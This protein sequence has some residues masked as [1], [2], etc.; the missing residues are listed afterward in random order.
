MPAVAFKRYQAVLDG[1][2]M[3]I[4]ERILTLYAR[5][6]EFRRAVIPIAPGFPGA[7]NKKT[8][9]ACTP[10]VWRAEAA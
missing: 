5:W 8:A 1:T 10:A 6:H 3:R 2:K 9:E 7:T 4:Q